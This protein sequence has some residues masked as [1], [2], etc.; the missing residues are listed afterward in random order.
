MVGEEVISGGDG[1]EGA[2]RFSDVFVGLAVL[3]W[4]MAL[5]FVARASMVSTLALARR[6]CGRRGIAGFPAEATIVCLFEAFSGLGKHGTVS[7]PVGAGL[8]SASESIC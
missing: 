1:G 5:E 7:L 4:T 3:T 2:R 6:R 8:W